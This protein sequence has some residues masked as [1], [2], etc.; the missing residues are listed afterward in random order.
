M[1]ITP[2]FSDLRGLT[3][4]VRT[5]AAA[6]QR[7]ERILLIAGPGSGAVAI[8]NR[9][10]GLLPEMTEAQASHVSVVQDNAGMRPTGRRPFRAPHHTC[11]WAGMFGGTRSYVNDEGHKFERRTVGEMGLAQH[12]VLL[13]D[14][15]TELPRRTIEGIGCGIDD[16]TLLIA[17][18][19]P[20][21]CGMAAHPHKSRCTCTEAQRDRWVGRLGRLT[22]DLDIACIIEVPF[23][24]N[25][26]R[27]H[28]ER[29]PS[30]SDL[31]TEGLIEPAPDNA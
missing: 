29:C 6:V 13:L 20:C 27:A 30:T 15:A 21:P 14:E 3:D 17:R 28:G 8:A 12:G 5:F 19:L 18:V 11:S 10:V 26:A 24:S 22:A 1:T 4:A 2:D 9:A 23:L 16:S 25:E 7:G 31:L